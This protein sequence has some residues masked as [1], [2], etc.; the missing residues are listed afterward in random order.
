M[1]SSSL[2]TSLMTS[3][4]LGT[5]PAGFQLISRGPEESRKESHQ[6]K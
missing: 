4:P 6:L 2:M 3:T 5:T 1:N